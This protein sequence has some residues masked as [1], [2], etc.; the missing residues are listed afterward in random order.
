MSTVDLMQQRLAP[1][2]PVHLDI[3]DDSAHHAGHEGAK[4]GGGH[5]TLT[6]VSERFAGE[7]TLGRHRAI[8]AALGDLIPQRIHALSIRAYTPDE[9]FS[10]P[11]PKEN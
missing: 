7:S 9:F 10:T 2:A 4:G 11:N 1:L 3:A 5:Y 6:I 8:Y